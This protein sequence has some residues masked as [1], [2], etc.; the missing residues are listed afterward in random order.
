MLYFPKIGDNLNDEEVKDFAVLNFDEY[1]K[2]T[3]E[4]YSKTSEKQNFRKLLN[5]F[6]SL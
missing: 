6:I 4:L 2:S 3:R 5:R 1:F